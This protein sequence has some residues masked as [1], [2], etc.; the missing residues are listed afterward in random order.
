MSG[1]KKLKGEE[2][3][4]VGFFSNLGEA[5]IASNPGDLVRAGRVLVALARPV[6]VSDCNYETRAIAGQ[7]TKV[8]SLGDRCVRSN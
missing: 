3:P 1:E 5:T 4:S 7:H 2:N 6:G 8:A